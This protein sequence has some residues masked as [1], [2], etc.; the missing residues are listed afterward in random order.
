MCKHSILYTIENEASGGIGCPL[1]Q[2]EER[3]AEVD[4]FNARLD[5]GD[6]PAEASDAVSGGRY[7]VCGGFHAHSWKECAQLE[8]EIARSEVATVQAVRESFQS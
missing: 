2:A 8:A 6:T 5:E 4:A 7:V 1:C 3:N